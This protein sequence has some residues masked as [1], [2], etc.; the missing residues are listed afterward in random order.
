MEPIF[1]VLGGPAVGKSTTSRLLAES[2]PHSIHLPVDDIRHMVRGGLT[3]PAM[4]WTGEVTRQITLGRQA[5]LAVAE[6]YASSGYVVVI[7]D[8]WDP[9]HAAEYREFVRR[10]GVHGVLLHVPRDVA[11]QRNRVRSPGP[12]GDDIEGA[13]AH[14]SNIIES[15]LDRLPDAGWTVIDTSDRAPADT[16]A[17]IRALAGKPPA[18]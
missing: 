10:P 9:H 7:D 17:A 2:F 8:F 11:L 5:A 13:I 6:L 14:S 15:V 18:D 1:L 16:A 4:P 12:E 3:L